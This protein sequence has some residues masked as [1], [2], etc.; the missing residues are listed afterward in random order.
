M[1]NVILFNIDNPNRLDLYEKFFKLTD[2]NLLGLMSN[3]EDFNYGNYKKITKEDLKTLEFDLIFAH[4]TQIDLVKNMLIE[5][6]MPLSKSRIIYYDFNNVQKVIGDNNIKYLLY[7]IYEIKNGQ[8]EHNLGTKKLYGK[9]KENV[10]NLTEDEKNN[11]VRE[12]YESYKKQ[13][14]DLEN[15]PK[16]Y[17]VGPNWGNYMLAT[18]P[19]FYYAVKNDDISTLEKLLPN[20]LR[21]CLS[22]GMFGGKEAYEGFLTR[23]DTFG[24][25]FDTFKVW[26]GKIGGGE[27]NIEE[28]SMSPEGGGYGANIEGKLINLNSFFFHARATLCKRLLKTNEKSI[29]AEIGGGTGL[30]GHYLLNVGANSTYINFDLP[31][32]LISAS[33]YLKASFPNKKILLY[34]KK[35]Q[36]TR[37]MLLEYDIVL[38]PNYM[39]P[40]L[41]NNSI[42]MF[43]NTMSFGEMSYETICEYY[44][45]IERCGRNYF[46][47]ENL[48]MPQGDYVS[49]PVST[50]PKLGNY[51]LIYETPSSWAG[52]FDAMN[53]NHMF[54]EQLFKKTI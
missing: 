14:Q 25:Y 41:E 6:N 34:D 50:Y 1:L 10:S 13:I 24:I 51:E 53:K 23:K 22:T 43:I 7:D 2:F 35:K 20:F 44:S 48:F 42:D 4:Y 17:Q 39:I 12:V 21:N 5:L 26:L 36:L 40:Y 31:D 49:Y 33:Y 37:E 3:R 46:Y 15:I 38:M 32:N 27:P 28:L 54:V 52:I 16:V 29:V 8:L 18:R 19:E 47:H 30:L 9:F 45:Q 11:I